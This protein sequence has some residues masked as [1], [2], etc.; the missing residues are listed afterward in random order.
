MSQRRVLVFPDSGPRVG[1]GHVM[2]CLTLARALT[3]RGASCAFAATP[4]T[5]A[6]LA[7]FGAPDIQTFPVIGEPEESAAQA[8]SWASAFHAD[9]VL[10]D[11]YGLEP[12]QEAALGE[13]RRLAVLDDLANRPRPADLLLNSGYGRTADDYRDLVAPDT[14]VLVGP[15]YAPVRPEFAARR[16]ASLARR[17]EGGHLRH[18]LIALGLTDVDGITRRVIKAAEPLLDGMIL[19]VAMGAA[20]PSLP[21]LREA[22]KHSPSLRLHIDTHAMAE[23]IENADLAIGAGGSSVWER[24]VLGLP[25]LTITLAENQRPMARVMAADGLL[26]T[27]DAAA[28]DFADRV[29][30]ALHRLIEDPSL[31]RELSN[32]TAAL[33][34]GRG[35]ERFAEALLTF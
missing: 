33:C 3:Q 19:D 13:G 11:H 32:R 8:V 27:A 24:A 35:A 16:D 1:G 14:L 34:D 25:T 20:G 18:A 10:L 28:P 23:L 17:R 31:R 29:T 30:R 22:A 7:A 4:S 2:R 9:W 12:E 6:I 26:L 15:T 5:Q 21:S